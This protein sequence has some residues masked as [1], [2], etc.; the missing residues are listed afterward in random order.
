MGV[1]YTAV[2]M[3][4]KEFDSAAEAANFLRS[5]GI[6]L[7]DEDSEEMEDGLEECLGGEDAHGLE[8]ERLNYYSPWDGG[9]L[10][11]SP[12]VREVDKFADQI[13]DMRA[14]WQELFGEEAGLILT[15]KVW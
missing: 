3:V 14:K 8:W 1:D 7:P 10:G 4:G 9:C 5:K 12:N 15:V 13:K 11:W 2:L 6:E